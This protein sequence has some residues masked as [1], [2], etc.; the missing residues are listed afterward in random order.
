[1]FVFSPEDEQLGEAERFAPEV[2][3]GLHASA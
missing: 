3:P 2:V 1:M